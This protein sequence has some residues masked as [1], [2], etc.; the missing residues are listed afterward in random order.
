MGA[1]FRGVG[2]L[3]G[4]AVLLLVLGIVLRGLGLVVWCLIVL[5]SI[6]RAIY[7]KRRNKTL[8]NQVASGSAPPLI[9]RTYS[10]NRQYE[11]DA[12]RLL[13]LGYEVQ[14]ERFD[15]KDNRHVTWR[16]SSR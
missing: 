9:A 13:A 12:K 3:I 4:F 2:Y 7:V 15:A 5:G 11:Q 8:A 14:A 10:G 1:I 6:A 16:Q